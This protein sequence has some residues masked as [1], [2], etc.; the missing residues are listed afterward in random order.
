MTTS[1]VRWACSAQVDLLGFSN[2]LM[3]AN[4]D[5]RTQTGKQAI[6]RLSSLEEALQLF[7]RERFAYPE[8]YPRALQCTRFNDTLFLG[9]D[10]E[11]LAPTTLTGGYSIGQLKTM[12]PQRGRGVFEGTP[13]ESGGDVAKFLGLVARIERGTSLNIR[14]RS[15]DRYLVT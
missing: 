3:V 13:A 14:T 7:E 15:R 4:W 12:H 1:G 6:E 2:H 5:I 10:V 11:H 9:I 8:L